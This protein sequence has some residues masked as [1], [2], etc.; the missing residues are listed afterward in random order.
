MKEKIRESK[1]HHEGRMSIWR[2]QCD[3][4]MEKKYEKEK[5]LNE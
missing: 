4:T 1:G 2:L 5:K 3:V